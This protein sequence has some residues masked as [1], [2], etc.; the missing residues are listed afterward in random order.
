VR[1]TMFAIIVVAMDLEEKRERREETRESA[2]EPLCRYFTQ[3]DKQLDIIL[4]RGETI[5]CY[6]TF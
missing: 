4:L 2:S 5:I 6:C 1:L 3:F